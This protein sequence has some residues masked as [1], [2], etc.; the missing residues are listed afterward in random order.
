M[1]A[2]E[3]KKQLDTVTQALG[4]LESEVEQ[5]TGEWQVLCNQNEAIESELKL[6]EG[7]VNRSSAMLE[8]LA[9]ERCRWFLFPFILLF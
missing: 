3:T 6:V 9:K 2:E 7:K 5:L 8:N 4:R 1:S